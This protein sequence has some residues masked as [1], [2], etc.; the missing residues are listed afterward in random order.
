MRLSKQYFRALNNAVETRT[1]RTSTRVINASLSAL[2]LTPEYKS[3]EWFRVTK[4]NKKYQ[5]ELINLGHICSGMELI[6]INTK[7]L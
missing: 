1:E 6:R 3:G 7:K 2:E 5:L 4:A